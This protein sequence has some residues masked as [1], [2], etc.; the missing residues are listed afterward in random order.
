MAATVLT[1]KVIVDNTGVSREMPVLIT[2]AGPV[3]S[4]I[5]YNLSL[6]RSLSWQEKLTRATKLFLEYLDVNTIPGEEEWRLFRNFAIALRSGTIDL[7]SHSDPSGLYW[8]SM[9]TGEANS[10]IKLL[11]DFL[12]WQARE[13]TPRAAKFN[14]AYKGNSYDQRLDQAAYIYRRNKAF[15]GHAWS[16]KPRDTASRLIR[17]ERVPKVF[18]TRP[19]MFPD[20]RFEELLFKGFKVAGRYDYR[21]MLITLMLFA[22]GLRVSEP[23]HLYMADVQPHWDDANS[24]F[25]PV[26]HP[27]LGYAPSQWKNHAGQ[28]GSRREYLA[29]EFGLAPRHLVRS[30]LHA[31]WKHPALDARWYMHVHWFPEFYGQWFK[32]MWTRYL[33]QVVSISRTHPYAWIN[34]D[35]NQGGIYTI[36]QYQKAL[37]NAVERIGLVYGKVYGT[38]A[39]G[40]R[41][42]YG[43]RARRAGINEVIIQRL[44]HHCSPESQLIYTQP[45]MHEAMAAIRTATEFLGK[46]HSRYSNPFA[47]DIGLP[48]GGDA[49]AI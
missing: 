35:K 29:A 38:T 37:Q 32:E 49:I 34:I 14:P 26:H 23:F 30:K 4:L 16:T 19:P 7:S 48:V 5:D 28:R 15:L 24:V 8:P 40:F 12:E 43:Q 25:V 17:G 33:E 18:P 46:S 42:A 20:E 41:H 13:N 39:H 44:M 10:M 36:S 22:G 27:S 6:H 1:G 11:S 2:P 47:M 45:E 21:G 31:G 9:D 3:R